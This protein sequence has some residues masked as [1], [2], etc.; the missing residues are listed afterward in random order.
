MIPVAII[1]KRVIGSSCLV[2]GF[3]MSLL[4]CAT[5]YLPIYFQAVKGVSPMLSGIY[6]LPSILSQLIAAVISGVLG[7]W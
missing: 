2:F 1:S 5:Y 4:Y 3:L 7:K 6:L